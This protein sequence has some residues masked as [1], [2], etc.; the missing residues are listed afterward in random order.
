MQRQ[1]QAEGASVQGVLSR[2][3][4][5]LARHYRSTGQTSIAQIALL[6]GCQDSSSF[7]RAYRGWAGTTSAAQPAGLRNR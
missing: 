4:E 2:T 3:R 1:R 6:L 5:S 7:H